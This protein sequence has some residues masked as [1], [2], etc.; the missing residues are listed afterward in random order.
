MSKPDPVAEKSGFLRMYMSGHPDTL[1]AYAKW[2]G[3]VEEVISSAEMTAIDTKVLFP[4]FS[5]EL[6]LPQSLQSMMLTCTL[7]NGNKKEV[8]I[9]IEPPLRGYEDVK[10]RL[11]EM[12]AF[13]QEG[14]GMV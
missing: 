5:W 12:K 7:K 6:Y 14:L 8:Y 13:A 9:P 11:L 10:P 4:L 3:K 1:V 2:F